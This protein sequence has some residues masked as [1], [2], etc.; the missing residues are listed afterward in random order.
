MPPTASSA[1]ATSM[2]RPRRWAAPPS[3]WPISAAAGSPAA[4]STST[5]RPARVERLIGVAPPREEAVRILQALGF[6]VHDSAPDLQ[7]VVPSFRRDVAQEDELI[8]EIIRI[9]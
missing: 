6:A 9:W 1:A 5:L 8:E 4:S 7:V 2:L 3:S